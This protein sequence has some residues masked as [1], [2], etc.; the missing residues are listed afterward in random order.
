[1]DKNISI[2][3]KYKHMSDHDHILNLPDTYI[4]GIEEDSWRMWVYDDL[5]NKIIYK[6]IK[7]IPGLY[8]IIDEII[9]NARDN[10]IK[11]PTCNKIKF[12]INPTTGEIT[13]WNNGRD[14][15]PLVIHKTEKV[16]LPEML[17]SIIR[18][19]SHYDEKNK[20]VGGR[21]GIGAKATNIFSKN[22]QIQIL[23]G[24]TKYTQD[25]SN[26]MRT[27]ELPT[28]ENLTNNTNKKNNYIQIK[29][30]PD[31]TRFGVENI[32]PDMI[33]LIKKRIFDIAAVTNI[34]VYLDD[35]LIK[36]PGFDKY[37]NLY[38][39]DE[40]NISDRMVYQIISDR[41][42]VAAIYDNN[43]GY[44][45]ISFVNG[46][47][48]YQG[49]SHVAHVTDQISAELLKLITDKA[50]N[51]NLK[52]KPAQIRDNLTIFI[53]CVIVDPAFSSQTKEFLT[54][55]IA[56]FGSRCEIPASFIQELSKTGLVE[57]IE[58]FARFR[59]LEDLKKTDGKKKKLYVVSTN[60][61]TPIGPE[62]ANPTC[63]I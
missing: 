35:K 51:K 29:F 2:E 8:K 13:C 10:T 59:A 17:F 24:N 27:R 60:S 14:M 46:I 42:K 49:G 21:N 43:S 28:L 1:M 32:T 53:D 61:K 11:D 47:C 33:S 48:T 31:Y 38:Y 4:G 62:P 39:D 55:K 12:N 36:I 63:V 15:M 18:T 23:N 30:T 57:E 58:N 20:I 56:S 16:Y 7:Y 22:F 25:F 37:I 3:E 41:W 45:Q 50:K 40:S 6:S 54:N 52:I 44:R 19:S 5:T 9:V 26:N 34:E